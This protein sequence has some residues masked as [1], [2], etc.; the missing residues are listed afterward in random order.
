VNA[1]AVAPHDLLPQRLGPQRVRE[2]RL[3]LRGPRAQHVPARALRDVGEEARLADPRLALDDEH[4]PAGGD[5][6]GDRL[7]LGRASH[8]AGDRGSVHL[9][10]LSLGASVR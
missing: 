4:A 9:T 5:R 1:V 8:E 2:V 10:I 3:E 7:A 6:R